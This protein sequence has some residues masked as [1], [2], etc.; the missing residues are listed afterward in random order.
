MEL[1]VY[2]VEAE[3]EAHHWWF[4]GRRS[5]LA[6]R[7]KALKLDPNAAILD[8]GTSTGTNLRM[9]RDLGM[10]NVMGLDLSPEAIE[11]CR[12]KGLG[13]VCLG[14][15]NAIPFEDCSFDMVFATDIIE[16]VDNDE[17]AIAELFRV[18]RTGGHAIITVPA[19]QMLWG[20][21]DIVSMHKRRYRMTHLAR[22]IQAAGFTIKEKFY[23]NYLLFLPILLVRIL[24]RVIPHRL[25]SENQ[26]N[27]P[28][29]NALLTCIFS[30]D[31]YTA[32]LISPPF[33]VSIFMMLEKAK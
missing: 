27:S 28:Q 9:L 2:A 7:L 6:S 15:V 31:V 8:V 17:K 21:Q 18:L 32:S 4:R 24:L 16:H 20:L 5:L 13:D 22:K 11:F 1:D 25:S 19:F 26:L 29:I 33:G 3:V 23:F 30:F 12:T 14:D 10:P